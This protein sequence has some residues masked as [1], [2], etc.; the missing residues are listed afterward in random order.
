[1]IYHGSP[2]DIQ[3]YLDAPAI[4]QSLLKLLCKGVSYYNENLTEEQ[5]SLYFE[6]KEHFLIGS[7]VDCRLTQPDGRYQEI[8]YTSSESKPSD[9]IMSIV[10]MVYDSLKRKGSI[11]EE[12]R[13]VESLELVK[14]IEAHNYQSNWKIETKLAKVIKDGSTYWKE[15][16]DS[17]GKTILSVEQEYLVDSIV[18]SLL[19]NERTKNIFLKGKLNPNFDVIFQFPVFFKTLDVNCKGLLDIVVVDHES[20]SIIP[21][22]LKTIGDYTTNFPA[23]VRKRRY[24]FQAAFYMEGIQ[25]SL[26]ALSILIDKKLEGYSV[27]EFTFIVES[28]KRV[29][30]PLVYICDLITLTIGKFGCRI[31]HEFEILFPNIEKR[32]ED[33]YYTKVMG[34]Y[35]ALK[36]YKYHRDHGFQYDREVVE[37]GGVMS[38]NYFGNTD[39]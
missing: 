33:K 30:N 12:L 15:L 23:A 6:E 9:T 36:L 31:P 7:A 26:A 35:E 21:I 1:M 2:E 16:I 32:I 13:E 20:K 4:N 19:T 22:D 24:D 28:T 34:F 27:K 29:G 18:T 14:A 11:I 39:L 8:Y 37:R 38:L 25:S 10:K 17:E 5:A 3:A